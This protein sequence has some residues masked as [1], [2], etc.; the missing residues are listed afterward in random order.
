MFDSITICNSKPTFIA[1]HCLCVCR[2]SFYYTI[3]CV[4]C[5]LFGKLS[6]PLDF[7]MTFTQKIVK[8]PKKLKK[9]DFK[10]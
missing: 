3:G 6:L 8:M 7:P 2:F 4:K 5:Q 1:Q 10:G 9:I